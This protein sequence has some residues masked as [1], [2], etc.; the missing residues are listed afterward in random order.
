[1][2]LRYLEYSCIVV[3][4]VMVAYKEYYRKLGFLFKNFM[5]SM[6]GVAIVVKHHYYIGQ[7]YHESAMVQIS[8]FG[9]DYISFGCYILCG[10]HLHVH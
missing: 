9:H 4:V 8:D 2:I 6:S 7:R 1:M 10:G 5:E 3:I